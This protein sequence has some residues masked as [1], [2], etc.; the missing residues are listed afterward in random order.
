VTAGDALALDLA[1]RVVA[2]A[3]TDRARLSG[4]STG[5]VLVTVPGHV[6]NPVREPLEE[7]SRLLAGLL[8]GVRHQPG[9]LRRTATI[10][11]SAAAVKRPSVGEHVQT[12]TLR[13][14]QPRQC[15][16]LVDDVFSFGRTT[17]ACRALV[18]DAGFPC[19]LV[20]AL[21]RTKLP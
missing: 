10:R 1:A 12:L 8:P 14:L 2:D 9:A 15:V 13:K 19:V 4:P 18:L 3:L 11:R 6:A 16:I 17:D 5:A 21:A 7:L 20:A